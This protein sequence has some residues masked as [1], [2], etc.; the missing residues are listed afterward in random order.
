MSAALAKR[1]SG[2]SGRKSP[3]MTGVRA[4]VWT[5]GT[6]AGDKNGDCQELRKDTCGLA[7]PL[8]QETMEGIG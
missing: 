2:V 7:Y 3:S 5:R 1:F 6:A 4:S 8:A